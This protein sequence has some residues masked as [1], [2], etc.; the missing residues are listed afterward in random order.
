MKKRKILVLGG[1]TAGWFTALFAK[2]Y[3]PHNEVTLVESKKIGVIGVGEA[4]TP[5]IVSFLLSEL[6]IQPL[7]VIRHTKGSVKNGISFENWNGDGKKYFHPFRDLHEFDNFSI[8]P[9]YGWDCYDFYLKTLVKKDLDF[10]EYSFNTKLSYMNKVNLQKTFYALH[11][12]AQLVV[13]GLAQVAKERGIIHIDDNYV[14]A[15]KHPKGPITGIRFKKN[16][17]IKCDFVFDCSGFSRHLI[18]KTYKQK[19]I[20]YKKHLPLDKAIICPRSYKKKEEIFPYTKCTALKYGWMFQIPLQHRIGRGYIFDSSYITPEQ[21]KQEVEKTFKEK[22]TVTKTIDFEAGRMENFWV[23][24][25]MAVGLSS[26][27]IEPLESTSIY[28]TIGQL[29]TLKQFFDNM[30]SADPDLINLFNSNVG[31]S[32]DDTM[33]FVYLHYLTKR[34][35]S[36]FWKDFRK[37]HPMPDSLKERFSL[38]EKCQ[39]N[40]FNFQQNTAASFSLYSYLHIARGLELFKQKPSMENYHNLTPSVKQYKTMIDKVTKESMTHKQFLKELNEQG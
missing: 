14:S 24:N 21:A 11:F 10:N 1:G 7:D 20:S 40:P 22:I 27:F 19:W 3:F 2:K 23:H 26:S 15:L 4:P 39:L 32:F 38:L 5:H 18:Q 28:L 31:G 17:I 6:N 12:D 13:E 33:N 25:C 16:G 34:K 36:P 29:T 35:D 9:V 8:P 30:F 37:K